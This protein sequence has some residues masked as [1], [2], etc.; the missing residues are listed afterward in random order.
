MKPGSNGEHALQQQYDSADRANAFYDAQMLDHLN[1]RMIR[2]IQRQEMMFVATADKQGESDC[3]F[4]AGLPG[5]V[6]VLDNQ[7]LVYPCLLYTSD[8]A[9]E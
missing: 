9:D 2:L 3:S 4:R 8:A 7:T 5:F 1:K 6:V